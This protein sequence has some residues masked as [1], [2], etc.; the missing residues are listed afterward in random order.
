MSLDKLNAD[1]SR[2][3]RAADLLE[4]DL[5]TEAFA[6][7][8]TAYTAAWRSTLIDDVSGREKLF[9]AVNVV[10]KVRDHLTLMVN[11][12]KLASAELRALAQTAEQPRR[13][14]DV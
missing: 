1:R 2:A 9:L 10:G 3:M 12:G 6:A 4:N 14:A 7:L 5:L 13:W 11:D 8:E